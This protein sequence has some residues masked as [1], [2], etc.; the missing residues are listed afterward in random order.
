M[1]IYNSLETVKKTGNEITDIFINLGEL[2]P[3][4][5]VVKKSLSSDSDDS[6][7]FSKI[8]ELL[9]KLSSTQ[10]TTVQEEKNFF[11]QYNTKYSELFEK[12]KNK[13]EELKKITLR[14]NNIRLNSEDLEIVALNAMV[15]SIKA[16]EKSRGFS[17]T[18]KM[19]KQISEE[20]IKISSQLIYREKNLT[21]NI[22]KLNKIFEDIQIIRADIETM[23]DFGSIAVNNVIAL[24]HDPLQKI[25]EQTEIIQ[26]DIQSAMEGL[27]M[28]DIIRQS[29][30]QVILCLEQI[31]EQEKDEE[32]GYKTLLDS[33]TYDLVLLNLVEKVLV[34]VFNNIVNIVEIFNKNW[35]AVT[36][37]LTDIETMR[38]EYIGNFKEKNSSI[39]GEIEKIVNNFKKASESIEIY[40]T[41]QKNMMQTS[42]NISGEASDMQD[43]FDK[44]SP[45]MKR[46]NNV[47]VCQQIEVAKNQDIKNI[48]NTVE[49]MNK[50]IE[51]SA[52]EIDTAKK[53][54]FAC[55]KN[56]DEIISALTLETWHDENTLSDLQKLR[57]LFFKNLEATNTSLKIVLANFSVFPDEFLMLCNKIG[58]LLNNLSKMGG[59]IEVMQKNISVV[60]ENIEKNRDTL[61]ESNGL[62]KWDIHSDKLK[63]LIDHFTITTH[64][65]EAGKIAGFDV[66]TGNETGEITFF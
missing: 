2:F 34:D 57:N 19:L 13:V 51:D 8:K 53:E 11:N 63:E 31:I 45:I 44:L 10:N 25:E 65:V 58:N 40:Q 3:S 23:N 43:D 38:L 17:Y 27:Q 66:E 6:N 15:I 20:M 26:H 61:L 33:Y 7:S 48:E 28:Q 1:T 59:K 52:I 9:E 29:L 16:G 32:S 46:L 47:R 55:I 14:I 5:L 30:D 36:K 42:S 4:L 22:E 60:I 49:H 24:L 18:T 41:T 62:D 50:L 37:Q 12:L 64:K 56:V 39:I 54:I 21:K 35:S